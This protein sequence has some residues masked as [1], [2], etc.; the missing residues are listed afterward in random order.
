MSRL[1][2]V[3]AFLLCHAIV[4]A[5]HR[6]FSNKSNSVG[7]VSS[8]ETILMD[9][10]FRSKD[11][12]VVVDH[13]NELLQTAKAKKSAELEII[14]DLLAAD[15]Y[16]K[17]SDKVNPRSDLCY[18][19]ALSS[20][21]RIQNDE[22]RLIVLIR[23]GYYYFV[24]REL[25][26]AIPYF[27][28]AGELIGQVDYKAVP[29]FSRHIHQISSFYGYIGNYSGA[30]NLLQ[31]GLPYCK[32]GTALHISMVNSMGVYSEKQ[33]LLGQA[34]VHFQRALGIAERNQDSLWMGII[35]GNLASI[36]EQKGNPYKAIRLLKENVRLSVKY[37][38]HLD[39]MRSMI[40]LADVLIDVGGWQEA[41]GYLTRSEVYVKSKPFFLPIKTRIAKLRSEIASIKGYQAD[42]LLYLKQYVH[43]DDS[44][45]A[46]E[47]YDELQRAY[48]QWQSDDFQRSIAAAHEE[49][50]TSLLL[51]L[52][53]GLLLTSVLIIVILL[54]NRS[55]NRHK[56]KST[57]L[58]KEQLT[59]A[60]EREVLNKELEKI[61]N[62]WKEADEKSKESTSLIAGLQNDLEKLGK[63]N[64][65]IKVRSVEVLD[66]LLKEPI[67]TDDR[68]TKFK[69]TFD[70]VFPDYLKKK[71]AKY[72][73][74]TEGDLRL[75]ALM[76]LKYSNMGMSS[77][78]GI[79]MDGVKKGKQRLKKKME[80]PSE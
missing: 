71:K 10:N 79:S 23:Q 13:L 11:S 61:T 63:E 40:K 46:T 18:K 67:M 24:Y 78:L 50:K 65:D 66:E 26:A 49:R 5:Q 58:E 52:A 48:W 80:D 56:I 76:K 32:D 72:P 35:F 2:C 20:A 12:T 68:W 60:L 25:E 74:L 1:L 70:Q 59:Y 30:I 15:Y 47:R 64:T 6:S 36:E 73:R 29:L 77:L 42:E 62:S 39:A 44:L 14:H 7:S 51:E 21:K 53:F 31:E 17:L 28:Q 37:S 9:Q 55:K 8:L 16:S 3:I 22:L 54:L 34:V 75:L 69:L 33:Q 45:R 4:Q 38:E 43:Y 27:L 41:E 19:K 57:M